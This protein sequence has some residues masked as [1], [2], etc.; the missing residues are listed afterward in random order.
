MKYAKTMYIKYIQKKHMVEKGSMPPNAN[1]DGT[2]ELR[3]RGTV[4]NMYYTQCFF[5][6]SQQR[7]VTCREIGRSR[8]DAVEFAS[9]LFYPHL[10]TK[11]RK[12]LVCFSS[13]LFTSRSVTSDCQLFLLSKNKI[14]LISCIYL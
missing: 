2:S 11:I 1:N 12:P 8:G 5:I 14:K 9:S 13:N 4:P 7:L 6:V 10:A 3:L